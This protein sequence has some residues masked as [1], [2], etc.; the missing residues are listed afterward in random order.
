MGRAQYAPDML[1][2]NPLLSEAGFSTVKDGHTIYRIGIRLNPLLSEAGFST[3]SRCALVSFRARRL[4]P[5]LSEAG[6][7]T[8]PTLHQETHRG[9]HVLILF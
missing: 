1:R 5:L 3:W 9:R 8:H 2:L 6:F 4:N 7:S